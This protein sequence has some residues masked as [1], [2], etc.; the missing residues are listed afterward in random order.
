MRTKITRVQL[1]EGDTF[2]I[3]V[4]LDTELEL[5]TITDFSDVSEHKI[6][7]TEELATQLVDILM[8]MLE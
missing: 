4:E 2:D 3:D 5:I 7:L 8:G 6:V 1:T